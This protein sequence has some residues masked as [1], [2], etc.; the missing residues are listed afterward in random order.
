MNWL[1]P[2]LWNNISVVGVIVAVAVYHITA[3]MRGWWVPG[4]YHREMLAI[5]DRQLDAADV[6]SAK[7]AE[8]M[9]VQAQT[10]ADSNARDVATTH[11]LQSVRELAERRD[12]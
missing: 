7:D 2:T 11:L 12:V 9:H 3:Y 6:R 1:N 10:I 8:T 5:K 4:K